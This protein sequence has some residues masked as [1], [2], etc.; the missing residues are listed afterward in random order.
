MA[1]E[2][3]RFDEFR[4]E[5]DFDI[6][7]IDRAA[8]DA[9][10]T[11]R[12]VLT[13]AGEGDTDQQLAVYATIPE[14]VDRDRTPVWR[15]DAFSDD[16]GR[17]KHFDA[18]LAVALNRPVL[19]VNNPGIDDVEWRDLS[20]G[21]AYKLTDDQREDLKKGSFRR[22]ARATLH[23]LKSASAG[24]GLPEGI[25]IASSSMGVALTGGALGEAK[26]VGVD[27]KG[28]AIEEG[29]NYLPSSSMLG[30]AKR[31]LGEGAH[32]KGYLEQ[33]PMRP[34]EGPDEESQPVL[35]PEAPTA[36]LGRVFRAGGANA[37]YARAM[38]KGKWLE[39]AKLTRDGE[40]EL[41]EQ[42]FPVFIS[43]GSESQLSSAEGDHLVE[44]R[45]RARG[46][47]VVKSTVYE[48]H[49]HPYTMTVQAYKEAVKQLELA[50]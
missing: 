26:T 8:Q 25:I 2:K 38:A 32:N 18:L 20:I 22:I 29:V 34:T 6:D 27:I 23:A 28:V 41:A 1:T 49:R 12:Y 50:A 37:A 30:F 39:D 40:H 16:P 31:F 15:P 36:W 42:E 9:H 43:R 11:R 14:G 35:P 19:T 45:L 44:K 7:V 47:Q 17:P 24:F 46:F 33:N 48:T 4:F 5:T 3:P 13:G 10:D 21:D